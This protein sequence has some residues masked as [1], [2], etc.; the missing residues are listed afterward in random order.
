M[1]DT[2]EIIKGKTENTAD[3]DTIHPV[4]KIFK[5]ESKDTFPI[6]S[7]KEPSGNYV[8]V[9]TPDWYFLLI[10]A[11]II[12]LAWIKIIFEKHIINFLSS[13]INYQVSLKVFNDA[14]IVRK[15]LGY[16]L[17]SIYLISVGMYMFALSGYFRIAPYKLSGIYLLLF[18][19]GIL[20][21]LAAIRLIIAGV[22]SI[23]FDRV[24]LFSEYIHHYY[25]YSK[26]LGLV[27]LP[28]ILLIPYTEGFLQQLSVYL[29]FMVVISVFI[30]RIIRISSFIIKNVVLYF[31]LFLYLCV[32]EFMPILIIIRLMMSLEQGS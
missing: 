17:N 26:V 2:T 18:Y 10:V 13:S 7:T 31:Y 20:L 24:K 27:I 16:I 3:T 22:T 12:S 29:S 19:I 32:L 23:F 1:N 14:G 9:S 8:P 15:R 21:G 28:F 4:N 6:L 11:L 5:G 30:S 25:L